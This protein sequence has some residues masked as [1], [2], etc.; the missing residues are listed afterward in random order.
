M[1]TSLKIKVGAAGTAFALAFALGV[2]SSGTT[3]AYFSD[4]KVGGITG[5]IATVGLSTTPVT[6][7]WPNMVA[8]QLQV[9]TVGFTNTG[10]IPQDVY[11]SFYNRPALHALNTLGT[12]GE[13]HVTSTSLGGVLPFDSKN[14]QDGRHD[15][16][17]GSGVTYNSC[18][19]VFNKTLPACWPLPPSLK[20]AGNVPV[21]G[22]GSVTFSFKYAATATVS[23]VF[24]S[25]PL[26]L[27]TQSNNPLDSAGPAGNGLPIQIIAVQ[28]GRII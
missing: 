26:T 14:L 21:G 5:T 13:V 23:G 4:T 25:Y 20:I 12:A 18:G 3:G 19:N 7:T 6:V 8:G 24:N 11:I 22:T 17:L 2:M 27:L 9:V 1:R 28:V 15:T 10:S 16:A